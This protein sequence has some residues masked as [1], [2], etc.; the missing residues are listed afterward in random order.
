MMHGTYSVE[1]LQKIALTDGY[2]PCCYTPTLVALYLSD[3][4]TFGCF[5]EYET[6]ALVYF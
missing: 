5:F 6:R 4:S 2:Y 1:M 3:I